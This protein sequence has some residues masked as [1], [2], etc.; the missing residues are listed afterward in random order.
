MILSLKTFFIVSFLAFFSG[1]F[2]IAGLYTTIP[3]VNTN[4]KDTG[5]SFHRYE[6]SLENYSP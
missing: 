6:I 1:S 4:L 5:Y 3:L 2:I